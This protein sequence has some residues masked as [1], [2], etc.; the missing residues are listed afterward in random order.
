[1]S[2]PIPINEI[3]QGDVL[4]R[5]KTLPDKSVNCVV[6]SPPYW[7]LRDY[8]VEGQLGLE[9]TPEEFITKLVLIFRE[10]R[11]VLRDDGTCWVN[12]GDSYAGSGKGRNADGTHQEGGK[13]GTSRG[14]VEGNLYKAKVSETGFKPKDL[15]GIP[16]RFALAAQADG[17]YLRQDIIWHKPNP[18]PESVTDRCTKAHEYIFLLT[19]AARYWYDAEAIKEDATE[20]KVCGQNSRVFQDRDPNHPVERKMRPVYGAPEGQ[21]PNGKNQTGRTN[22]GKDVPC[23]GKRNKRSVWTIPTQAYSEAHFATFPEKLVEP[24]ILAGCPKEVCPKCGKARLRIVDAKRTNPISRED[25]QTATG[26][27]LSGGVGKNFPETEITTIG[28]SDCGCNA[29]FVPG[30]VLDP[31]IGSGTTGLVAAK[32]ERSFLGIELNPKYIDLAYNRIIKGI[33]KHLYG[34]PKKPKAVK[35]AV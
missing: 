21:T 8:G 1:M 10:V 15:V 30:L 28:W 29:G 34:K 12:L 32:N 23:D 22:G 17:W 19:K 9:K 25:R 11:R 7:G 24:C 18:M 27:A 33:E 5:L 14:T 35:E 20:A 31:F 16:W 2:A 26:G 6:T 3:L 13:Q 4:D